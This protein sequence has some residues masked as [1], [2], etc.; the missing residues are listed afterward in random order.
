MVFQSQE[1]GRYPE[2]GVVRF[3]ARNFYKAQDRKAVRLL[4]LGCGPGPN[5]WYMDREGFDVYALDGSETAIGLLKKRFHAD[6]L[7][8]HAYVGDMISLPFQDGFFDGIIEAE[9]MYSNTLDNIKRIIREVHRTLKKGGMFYSQIFGRATT[10]FGKGDRIEEGTYRNITEG[11]FV[12]KGTAHFTDAEEIKML[13][14]G[15]S[16]LTVDTATRTDR[17]MN[18][19]EYMV[20][21]T[22]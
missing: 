3:V 2:L 5:A 17:G 11:P 8:C 4:D 1:W 18:I 15:F 21:A 6:G 9:A 22:K 12:G 16:K 7:R 14:S 20:I 13:F 19:Q 10:G